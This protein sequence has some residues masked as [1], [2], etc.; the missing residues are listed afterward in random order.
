[1]VELYPKNSIDDREIDMRQEMKEAL[2]GSL[3]DI[4]KEELFILRRMRRDDYD[5]LLPCVCI[6]STTNEGDKD[7]FC[8]Y[9]FGE[10]FLWDEQFFSGLHMLARKAGRRR[11]QATMIW[12]PA[13]IDPSVSFMYVPYFV[14]PS[15]Q[16]RII[17]PQ[18]D[19]EGKIVWPIRI[20]HYW[21]IDSTDPVRG[22][23]GRIEF[24]SL[25]LR[26][27]MAGGPNEQ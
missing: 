12:E 7:R 9:C 25:T 1:M 11:I 21:R 15:Q 27:N 23:D 22:N 2:T 18:I 24:W 20:Y 3:F 6:S 10:G 14:N 8:P 4:P 19:D 5:Q 26:E 13:I 17:A 16:D